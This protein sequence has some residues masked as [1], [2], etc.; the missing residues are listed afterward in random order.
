LTPL[1]GQQRG[2][3]LLEMMLVL[4]LLG[5]GTWLVIGQMPSTSYRAERESQWLAER[6]QRL[7]HQA[8]LEG[9]MYGL[10][11]Q[12][13]RWQ[14]KHWHAQGWRDLVL[15][16]GAGAQTLPSG[17]RLELDQPLET[18]EGIPQ[19]LML[20]GGEVTPFRLRYFYAER[21]MAEIVLDEQGRIHTLDELIEQT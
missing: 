19:V 13:N 21:L 12:P 5:I 20:P 4:L 16:Q 1:I 18:A 15:P 7:T 3:T 2:F 8:T 6:L 14:F 17:W 10:W 9:R 11:V